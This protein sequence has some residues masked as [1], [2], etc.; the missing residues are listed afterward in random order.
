MT[1]FKQKQQ[2]CILRFIKICISE[3]HENNSIM[4]RGEKIEVYSSE[5]FILYVKWYNII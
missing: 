4:D 5:I 1:E 2:Y 3:M